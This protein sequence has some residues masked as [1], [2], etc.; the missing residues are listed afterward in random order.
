MKTCWNLTEFFAYLGTWSATKGGVEA[1][2]DGSLKE[3]YRQL[4]AV[5]GDPLEPKE[6]RME[7]HCV[8]GENTP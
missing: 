8:V 5:W 4:L 1:L 3:A 2:G 6:V 7:F